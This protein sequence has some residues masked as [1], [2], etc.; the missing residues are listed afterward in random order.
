MKK[1]LFYLLII[2]FSSCNENLNQTDLPFNSQPDKIGK[3]F[4]KIFV[5][6]E[7]SKFKEFYQPWGDYN[8]SRGTFWSLSQIY[9][10]EKFNWEETDYDK[11]IT[12]KYN[13]YPGSID[14]YFITIYF[15]NRLNNQLFKINFK[16]SK[17][18]ENGNEGDKFYLSEVYSPIIIEVK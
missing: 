1:F 9:N 13:S 3:Y 16:L 18:N 2:L 11:C 8:T 5:N 7:E 6:G 14:D 15:K 17:Q 4:Y 12:T 10:G